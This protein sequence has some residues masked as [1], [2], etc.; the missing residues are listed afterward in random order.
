MGNLNMPST[1]RHMAELVY[2]AYYERACEWCREGIRRDGPIAYLTDH[3]T[4]W[5][6]HVECARTWQANQRDQIIDNCREN[7][8]L[9]RDLRSLE[10]VSGEP[11]S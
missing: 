4:R 9:A 10:I 11:S 3:G 5:R 7:D 1:Q 2:A 8:R 6:L